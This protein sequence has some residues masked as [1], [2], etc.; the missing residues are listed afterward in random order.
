[1]AQLNPGDKAPR[2]RGI[3]QYGNP[4]SLEDFKGK[5]LILYFYPKD[6]TPGCT[7]EACNFRDNYAPL[8]RKGYEVVGVSVD[9]TQSHQKFREKYNLPFT[10]IADEDKK[11]VEDYG[12]WGEKNMFGRKYMGTNRVT[13]VIDGEGI[14]KHVIRRVDSK[15]ATQQILDLETNP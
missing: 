2:F 10:L 9:S 7:A 15:N 6:D 14:I 3:D 5:N 8:T 4:V 12:V 13:F 11:I 1:M